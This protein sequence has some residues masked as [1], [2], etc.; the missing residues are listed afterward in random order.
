M[1]KNSIATGI[2]KIKQYFIKKAAKKQAKQFLDQAEKMGEGAAQAISNLIN[3]GDHMQ[4]GVVSSFFSTITKEKATIIELVEH[5]AP[6]IKGMIDIAKMVEEAMPKLE[7]AIK[8][9]KN[10]E[11]C[12][13]LKESLRETGKENMGYMSHMIELT[14]QDNERIGSKINSDWF[15]GLK[16]IIN[17][18]TAEEREARHKAGIN[19]YTILN[20]EGEE[21]KVSRKEYKEHKAQVMKDKK[22]FCEVKD[23]LGEVKETTKEEFS[24][25]ITTNRIV[26]RED[27]D[28]DMLEYLTD[29]YD[30]RTAKFVINRFNDDK[31]IKVK[32]VQN[33]ITKDIELKNIYSDIS[34]HL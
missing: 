26:F 23:N 13:K 17:N 12:S 24:D 19:N 8:S 10:I 20:E 31:V 1:A 30:K 29:K 5:N 32:I 27:I 4:Q 14:R 22:E 3:V 34:F 7:A 6:L 9:E 16:D 11:L 21:V 28:E 15:L 33:N 25:N 18:E 2:A